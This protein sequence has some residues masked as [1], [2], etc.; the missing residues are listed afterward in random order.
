[1][2]CAYFVD[3]FVRKFGC[4]IVL[5]LQLATCVHLVLDIIRLCANF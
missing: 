2:I 4:T 3:L 1:M 5:S